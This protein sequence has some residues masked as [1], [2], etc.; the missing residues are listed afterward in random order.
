MIRNRRARALASGALML[1][2]VIA[3]CGSSSSSS[4]KSTSPT[5]STATTAAKAGPAQ[6]KT[7][8]GVAAP[9]G[10]AKATPKALKKL[11]KV[12]Q[13]TGPAAH[14][15]GLSNQPLANQVS[16][17]DANLN[18]FWGQAF[19]KAKLQWPQTQEALI[20]SS[21]VQTGCSSR[22]MLAPT[23]PPL[24]CN[25][26]FF[27][28]IPWLQQNVDPQG[29][30]AL[31]FTASILWA[32][33][34]DDVLGNTQLLQQGKTSKADYGNQVLCFTGLWARTLSQQNL[35]EPGDAQAAARFFS[36]LQGVDNI[37]A[38]DVTP[39]SLTAAFFKGFKSGTWNS[40][41]IGA[42]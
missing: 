3:G 41:A 34:A 1:S 32:L 35:F 4:S 20:Q 2:V 16:A 24:L 29:A 37:T 27:W 28:P 7:I 21:P 42:S 31:A 30:V 26:T 6:L 17:L 23:D 33:H 8:K 11:P 15:K 14:I 40:C 10:A 36:S 18:G 9:A 5:A 19:A 38:P 25:N 12:V 13:H 39:Q 22:P